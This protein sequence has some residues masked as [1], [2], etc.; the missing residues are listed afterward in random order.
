MVCLRATEGSSGAEVA[1]VVGTVDNGLLAAL[2]GEEGPLGWWM[3]VVV[4]E[5]RLLLE[6]LSVL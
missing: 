2:Q 5:E 3:V 4:M 6:R 1:Q